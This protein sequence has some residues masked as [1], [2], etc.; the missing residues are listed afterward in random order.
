MKKNLLKI[1]TLLLTL[2]LFFALAAC[3]SGNK[4]VLAGTWTEDDPDFGLTTWKFDGKGGCSLS[5]DF[6]DQEGS[7]EIAG[8][9]VTIDME[10]WESPNVYEY[11]VGD[12]TLSLE[13]SEFA[14][15][16]NLTKK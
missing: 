3:G 11:T 8:D 12:G 1:L 5:T 16:Y 14:P 13:G 2:S 9:N 7:Y 15:S 10:L 6:F 4:D